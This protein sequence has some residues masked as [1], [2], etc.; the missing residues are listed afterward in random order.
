MVTHLKIRISNGKD[1]MELIW[2]IQTGDMD[3]QECIQVF[4]FLFITTVRSL[5]VSRCQ[6]WL[7]IF[8][9]I[10]QTPGPQAV[11]TMMFTPLNLALF[12]TILMP[13]QFVYE[14]CRSM[15]EHVLT[16]PVINY[17][18]YKIYIYYIIF[19]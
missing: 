6:K 2:N 15:N 10:F 3:I 16:T 17:D 14:I 9:K 5:E 8:Q 11:L 18:V 7:K 4:Q 12:D 19:I 1:L 13:M